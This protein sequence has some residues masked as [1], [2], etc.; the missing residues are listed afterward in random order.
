MRHRLARG[1]LLVGCVASVGLLALTVAVWI[2]GTGGRVS[3]SRLDTAGGRLVIW[4]AE[5]TA[6][7]RACLWRWEIAAVAG[8][9]DFVATYATGPESPGWHA[10]RPPQP[11][12]TDWA[13]L[14]GKRG[15]QVG[16][17]GVGYRS[18]ASGS[19]LVSSTQWAAAP[20]WAIAVAS[21]AWPV[22]TVAWW[23]RRRR[24]DRWRAGHC[25]R[26]GY[27]LRAS[28][29]RCPECGAIGGGAVA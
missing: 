25:R 28:P 22:V 18:E 4:A 12:G 26:C 6:D 9:T 16:R 20:V 23:W 5:A 2:G 21:A 19:A 24:A 7:G 11:V 29:G 13:A 10:G 27:D 1:V 17:F 3:Y 14:P 8:P 15:V